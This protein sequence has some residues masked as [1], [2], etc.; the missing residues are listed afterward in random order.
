[1]FKGKIN[2][3][4]RYLTENNDHVILP[5]TPETIKELK[6]KHPEPAKIYKDALLTGLTQKIP[7]SYF[8]KIDQNL[9]KSS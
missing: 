2:A 3:A 4:L 7:S 1:M 9:T 5:S 6:E 8:D